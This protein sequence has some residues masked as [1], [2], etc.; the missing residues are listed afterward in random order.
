MDPLKQMEQAVNSLIAEGQP[1]ALEDVTIRGHSYRSYSHQPTSLPEYLASMRKHAAKDWVVLGDERYSYAEGYQLGVQFAAALQQR[2]AIGKGD[3]V[4]IVMRNNPQW[5]IGFIGAALAG[6]IVVPMNGWWTTEE[7]EYGIEDS[8]ATLI[9]AD[10]QRASRMQPFADRLGLRLVGVGDFSELKLDVV[11]FMDLCAEFAGAE[12]PVLSIDP[13]DDACIMYTSGSTGHP[14]GAVQ[15]HR[16]IMA[17]LFSWL[18]LGNA[19]NLAQKPPSD[20]GGSDPTGSVG[21]GA[22]G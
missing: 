11:D 21:G 8:G 4:A 18:L 22:G 20:P 12:A 13:E 5:M 16:G 19:G 9:I 17:A 6:A 15:T 14:K 3:R 1:F 2:Y 7:L 10:P